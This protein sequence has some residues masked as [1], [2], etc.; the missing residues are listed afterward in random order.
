MGDQTGS[1]VP[2][3]FSLCSRSWFVP[4]L[5]SVHVLFRFCSRFVHGLFRPVFTFCSCF[6]LCSPFVPLLF[7]FCSA[8]RGT[9]EEQTV[10]GEQKVNTR[11]ASKRTKREQNENKTGTNHERG[12]NGQRGTNHERNRTRTNGQRREE[13]TGN[14]LFS[15]SLSISL[16]IPGRVL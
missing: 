1:H 16:D 15:I 14:K 7:T 13:Q 4:V 6:V 5:F 11:P 10:N 12:T 9:K 2:V 8:P 3:L